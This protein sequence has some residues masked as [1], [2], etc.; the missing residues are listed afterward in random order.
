MLRAGKEKWYITLKGDTSRKITYS[1]NQ[2]Q[3][4]RN[5]TI[6][7]LTVKMTEE[8]NTVLTSSHEDIKITTTLENDLQTSWT[9]LL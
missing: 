8:G 3:Q 2:Q 6:E 5:R 9:E 4:Q 7:G 1:Q